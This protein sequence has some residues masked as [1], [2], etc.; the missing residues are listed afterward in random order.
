MMDKASVRQLALDVLCRVD[1]TGAFADQLVSRVAAARDLSDQARAFL[2]ELTYGVLRWRNRLDW[3]LGQCSTRSLDTLTPRVGNLLRLGAYQLTM[4]QRIPAFAAVSETV[5]LARQIEHAGV[6]AYVNAVLRSVA[7]HQ[8]V[9]YPPSEAEDPR[10]YLTISLSHPQW[11]I[12]RWLARYGQR[13][14]VAMCQANNRLPPFVVRVNRACTERAQLIAALIAEGC[15]AEPCHFAPDGVLLRAHPRLDQLSSYRRGW[16][17][18]QDEAAML[19]SYLLAPSP[20]E[21]ILD[22]C[23]A[24][25]G[26]AT[27]LA[28]LMGGQGQVICLDQNP[29]RLGMVE[30]NRA[31]LGLENLACIVGDATATVFA[32]SFDRILVDAPCSGLGVLRRH[33]DAKWR[34]DVTLIDAMSRQQIAILDWLSQ[35]LKPDGMMLYVTCSTEPEENQVVVQTFLHHHPDFQ[36]ERIQGIL[37]PSA[38]GFVHEEHWFQTWPGPEDLDGFFA[39]RLRRFRLGVG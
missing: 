36:L 15:Q 1:T 11:L 9:L 4:M 16:F 29:R 10:A 22:A 14:T 28:E 31:R 39:A 23:A 32:H 6:A 26:K 5:R 35:F 38:H 37:P 12:E 33:P 27:H 8:D 13:R 20:G 18:V 34:K 19:C 7:R 17:T 21:R 2:R 24:P 30:A 3:L 25:G